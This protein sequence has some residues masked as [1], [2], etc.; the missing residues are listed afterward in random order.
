MHDE[1]AVKTLRKKLNC[2]EVVD[3]MLNG[4]PE[5]V[6]SGIEQL[7]IHLTGGALDKYVFRHA[8][9]IRSSPDLQQRIQPALDF[10]IE[11]AFGEAAEYV[12]RGQPEILDIHYRN[13]HVFA[14]TVARFNPDLTPS[15]HRQLS[16]ILQPVEKELSPYLILVSL[17]ALGYMPNKASNW[18]EDYVQPWRSDPGSRE[19]NARGTHTAAYNARP[20][21]GWGLLQLHPRNAKEFLRKNRR[22]ITRSLVLEMYRKCCSDPSVNVLWLAA[23][24]FKLHQTLHVINGRGAYAQL[25]EDLARKVLMIA[26]EAVWPALRK[27]A[28]FSGKNQLEGIV[29]P[30]VY[31]IKRKLKKKPN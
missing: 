25:P 3:A 20:E 7:S 19:G 27:S 30:V 24:F 16:S 9:E 1:Y 11:A 31:N 12:N 14:T 5:I 4:R 18:D 26:E 13:F 17:R 8:H 10:L 21:L 2:I 6:R 29:G 22:S 23:R 15:F 28:V